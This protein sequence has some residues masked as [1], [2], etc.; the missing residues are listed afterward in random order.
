MSPRRARSRMLD[1]AV[2]TV[3][4]ACVCAPLLPIVHA[5][6]S[7]SN[8]SVVESGGTVD[9]RV[10]ENG[11]ISNP[12][13]GAFESGTSGRV[14]GSVQWDAYTTSA[15]GLKLVVSSD[16]TPAMRDAQGGVDVPDYS[17]TPTA[18][19]VS[20]GDRRFGF[21]VT[22][23]MTLGSLSNGPLWR[24]F[25]GAKGVEVARKAAPFG[26]TRTTLLL[27]A[28]LASRL[29][30]DARPTANITMTAVPNL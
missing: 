27:R 14:D 13:N 20:D 3:C 4:V 12:L 10:L 30:S 5:A 26:R 7:A 28:A 15:S 11:M 25:T 6:D 9:Q 1:L 8:P 16:R 23:D 24:G 21:T 18:W 17:A 22:G 2:A 19:S 29:G